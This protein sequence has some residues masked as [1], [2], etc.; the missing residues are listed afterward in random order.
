[1]YNEIQFILRKF[2]SV[3]LFLRLY[4]LFI[5]HKITYENNGVKI[6]EIKLFIYLFL[7]YNGCL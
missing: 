6:N 3:Y 5:A 7:N 4:S 1:M 2:V